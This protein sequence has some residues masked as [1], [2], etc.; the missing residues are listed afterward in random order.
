MT[1]S[2][3]GFCR[4]SA[5]PALVALS[6]ALLAGCANRQ[7]VTVGALPDDYRTNHPITIAEREQVT[8]IPIAQ[9]DQKLSPMQRGIVQAQSPITGAAAPACFMFWCLQAR[10]IRPPHTG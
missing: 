3:R 9:A 6:L 10:P 8:D 1:Y 7:H 4:I 2:V 5:R